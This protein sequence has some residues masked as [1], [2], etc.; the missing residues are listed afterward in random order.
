MMAV[1]RVSIKMLCIFNSIPMMYVSQLI[2]LGHTNRI[3][4]F[5]CNIIHSKHRSH[6]IQLAIGSYH[7]AG[8]FNRKDF[9]C[10]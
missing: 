8:I 4:S 6:A 2:T 9:L 10:L 1:S 3:N 7:M 5:L